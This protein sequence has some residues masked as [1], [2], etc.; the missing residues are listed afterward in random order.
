MFSNPV[1]KLSD[2]SYPSDT[3]VQFCNFPLLGIHAIPLVLYIIGMIKGYT[4]LLLISGKCIHV[5]E[6]TLTFS[7]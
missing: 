5:I 3:K 2:Y 6:R 1:R 7:C 4:F